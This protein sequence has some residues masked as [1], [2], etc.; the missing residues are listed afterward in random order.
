MKVGAITTPNQKGQIVIPKKM[1]ESLGIT[2]NVSLNLML[3]GNGLYIQPIKEVLVESEDED[4]YQ[5]L[6]KKTQ[7]KWKDED[8]QDLRKKR[9]KIEL[10]ASKKRKEKW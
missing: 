1:R 10:K 9:K 4:S 7:G 8:W 5:E 6:L 3:R 2:P